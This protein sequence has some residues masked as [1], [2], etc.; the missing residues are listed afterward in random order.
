MA[1][2]VAAAVA[3][4][5]PSAAG[6]P[7]RFVVAGVP[8]TAG[9][10]SAFVDQTLAA[11]TARAPELAAVVGQERQEALAAVV[12]QERQKALRAVSSLRHSRNTRRTVR[13]AWAE[14]VV[15]FV[16]G[17]NRRLGVRCGRCG[18][19]CGTGCRWT[20][21]TMAVP[22][23]SGVEADVAVITA[24]GALISQ[25]EG[26]EARR[27]LEEYRLGHSRSQ[28][29]Q[30]EYHE[31]GWARSPVASGAGRAGGS[32]RGCSRRGWRC[33]RCRRVREG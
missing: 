33:P 32:W 16:D 23:A 22:A 20:R 18:R 17:V 6:E 24:G 31:M 10:A 7:G 27:V 25:Q 8:L 1:R 5:V 15:D 2:R 14:A 28:R 9:L 30:D 13:A 11:V 19:C 4:Q 26:D 12:G 3:E 29:C 21:Q